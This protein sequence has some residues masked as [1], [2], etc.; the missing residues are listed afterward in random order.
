MIFDTSLKRY[1]IK[2]DLY[3][4]SEDIAYKNGPLV[5]PSIFKE[6]FAPRYKKI[7]N[8][9]KRKGIKIFI[10]ESDGNLEA[11]L[12]QLIECGINVNIPVEAA[13]G[14]DLSK[15]IKEYG[16][17]MAW[18]GGIDKRC[19]AAGKDAIKKELET[20][21]SYIKESGGCIPTIDGDIAIDTSLENFKFYIE[22]KSKYL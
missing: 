22:L 14:M 7:I 5:S 8:H 13:S 12:P 4:F 18:I 11:L 2:P 21:I 9:V 17:D 15:L 10:I 16:K 6:F 19:I 20:K 1:N 3:N